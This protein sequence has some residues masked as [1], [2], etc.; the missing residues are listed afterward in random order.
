ML[1]QISN[2]KLNLEEI[3]QKIITAMNEFKDYA[4]MIDTLLDNKEEFNDLSL[5]KSDI[6]NF[7]IEKDDNDNLKKINIFN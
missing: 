2:F 5:I 6:L 7:D 1:S 3:I 4:V